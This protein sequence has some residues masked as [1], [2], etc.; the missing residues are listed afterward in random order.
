MPKE[1]P[2]SVK[3]YTVGSLAG[4]IGLPGMPKRL[5]ERLPDMADT[6][7]SVCSNLGPGG[8]VSVIAAQYVRGPSSGGQML[9][10]PVQNVQIKNLN[11]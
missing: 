7:A 5:P 1:S 10:L 3:A 4:G 8:N 2:V 6:H 9:R 11:R